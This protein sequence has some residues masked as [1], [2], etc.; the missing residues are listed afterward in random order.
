MGKPSPPKPPP[1][2]PWNVAFAQERAARAQMEMDRAGFAL[3]AG[4]LART[5]M[6]ARRCD[7]C[8]APAAGVCGYCGSAM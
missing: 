5:P 7:G 4:Y 1:P 6:A 2:W 8:G 3:G